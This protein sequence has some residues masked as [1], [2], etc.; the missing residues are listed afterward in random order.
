MKFKHREK[1]YTINVTSRRGKIIVN[2][3]RFV[4]TTCGGYKGFKMFPEDTLHEKFEA[5]KDAD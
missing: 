2:N 5:V 4:T 1:G 3:D